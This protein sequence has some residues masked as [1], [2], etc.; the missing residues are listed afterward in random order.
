MGGHPG[1][2]VPKRWG[3]GGGQELRG[4]KNGSE[5]NTPPPNLDGSMCYWSDFV[6]SPHLAVGCSAVFGSYG[7]VA[8]GGGPANW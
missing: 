7:S 5:S 1:A 2:I 4:T 6:D 3:W 8:C